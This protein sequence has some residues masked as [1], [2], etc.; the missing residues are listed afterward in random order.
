MAAAQRGKSLT[1]RGR[2]WL[3]HLRQWQEAG[4]SQVQYCRQHDLSAAAFGWWK[5]RLNQRPQNGGLGPRVHTRAAVSRRRFVEIPISLANGSA[6][7]QADQFTYE[8]S[9]GNQRCLRLQ[10][11]FAVHQVEQLLTL[12]ETRC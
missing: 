1:E 12:L 10:K 6:P 8:I 2:F 11:D 5:R 7:P 9:L 4:G 3:R